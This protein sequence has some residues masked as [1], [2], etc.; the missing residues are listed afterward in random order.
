LAGDSAAPN[1]GGDSAAPK[2][3]GDSAYNDKGD[4]YVQFD[5]TFPDSLTPS[6]M[7]TLRGALSEVE[8]QEVTSLPPP[9]P[10]SSPGGNDSEG[11]LPVGSPRIA[12]RCSLGESADLERGAFVDKFKAM[13]KNQEMQEQKRAEARAAEGENEER[14][15]GGMSGGGAGGQ[16]CCIS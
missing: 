3:G 2:R 5:V 12:K 13:E 4:L 9:P 14:M 8:G 16:E 10:P 11:A 1:R 6:Q 15:G 7:A